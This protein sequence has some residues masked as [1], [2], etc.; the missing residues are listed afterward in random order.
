MEEIT[1]YDTTKCKTIAL[2]ALE[3]DQIIGRGDYLEC[4]DKRVSRNHGTLRLTKEGEDPVVRVTALHPTNFI[5]YRLKRSAGQLRLLKD[6]SVLL[7]PG[8]QFGL[9]PDSYWF[10][11]KGKESNNEEDTQPLEEPLNGQADTQPSEQTLRVRSVDEVNSE[12]S[13]DLDDA[14]NT[15]P[16]AKRKPDD[17]ANDETESDGARKRICT[18]DGDG[19]VASTSST[20]STNT[21]STST[22]DVDNLVKTV[23][24]DPDTTP[25]ASIV[26]VVKPD[27]DGTVGATNDVKPILSSAPSLAA[28][29][30]PLRPSCDF[31]IRCYRAGS[32]H[33]TQFAH[34]GDL[35]YR[36]PNFPPAPPGAPLCPFGAKCYR[37]NPQHFVD[38][39]HPDPN[40]Y[41]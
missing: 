14:P 6:E 2:P 5:F 25:S 17:T 15:A 26:T 35:D 41:F 32:D 22:Q 21:N 10:E 18:D 29:A 39:Q 3:C 28:N 31:G 19:Q 4:D 13:N 12:A 20:P 36:R 37:R 8:D 40:I 7:K 33:R 11:I 38:F 23:K 1:L 30:A 24:A 27:P 9:L 16:S 34:P